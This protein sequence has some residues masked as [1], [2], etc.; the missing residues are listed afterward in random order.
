[1]EEKKISGVYKITNIV[2]DDFY[3]GSSKNIEYRWAW[4]R[5]PSAWKKQPNFI[6]YKD[7]AI[8]GKDN[9]TFEVLEETAELHVREQYWIDHL[10]PT[11]N[12]IR[13][14]VDIDKHKELNRQLTRAWY[15][16]HREKKSAYNKVDNSRLCLYGNERLTLQA[17]TN[18][19]F[20][21]GIPH[22]RIE[23]KKYLI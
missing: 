1:M 2:T 8:L 18:R 23:A 4:H 16:V 6:L 3:I 20:R 21:Q 12:S 9:F 11:Y 17:L 22:A 15:K 10:N 5:R 7:M 13:A 14:Y 19:F